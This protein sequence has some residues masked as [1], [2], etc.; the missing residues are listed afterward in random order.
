MNNKY[1]L[2]FQVFYF[3]GINASAILNTLK[4]TLIFGFLTERK[5]NKNYAQEKKSCTRFN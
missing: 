4:D 2:N 3:S 1:Y 5:K